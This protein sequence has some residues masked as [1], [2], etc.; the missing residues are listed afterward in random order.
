[1]LDTKDERKKFIRRF[2][3]PLRKSLNEQ[4]INYQIFAR[5][6]AISSIWTKMH[7]NE[8]SFK[9]VFDVFAVK[10]VLDSSKSLEKINCNWCK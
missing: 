3:R 1:M 9:E 10:I 6:K 4:G 7:E 8:I 2:I 5:E